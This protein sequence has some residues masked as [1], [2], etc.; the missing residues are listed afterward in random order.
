MEVG[1]NKN[2]MTS[3]NVFK[4]YFTKRIVF[5]VLLILILIAGYKGSKFIQT[6]GYTGLWDFTSTVTSNYF[7]GMDA[8]PEQ[9]SIQIKEKDLKI[10]EI[11]RDKAL[12]RGVIINDL[13][14]EY[15]SATLDYNGKKMK[16]KMRLKGHMTDHIETEN[17][18]SFRIKV[19]DNDTFMGMK[20]FSIQQPGTR[21]YIYEWIYH[22]LMK[23]EDIIA[24][25]YKFINVSI[26]GK[27]WGI[28][29]VE[30]NFD[31]ELIE[32][33]NRKKGPILRLNPDFYWINR[34]NGMKREYITAEFASYYSANFEAYREDK[35]LDDSVQKQYYL[36]AIAL[37]D[38]F[39][40]KKLSVPQVFDVERLAK[41]HAIIDLV[42]G[43]HSIDWS[44]IK[45]YYNPVTAKLEPV[46]YESFSDFSV[47]E[48]SGNYKYVSVDNNEYYEDWHTALFS[49]PD[50]FRAYVKNL[51]RITQKQY[52]DDFFAA[53]NTELD[54]NLK[55]LY[56]EFPYKKFEKKSYYRNQ[57]MIKKILNEA[58][59]AFHAYYTSVTDNTIHLQIG[60][61]ESLPVELKSISVVNSVALPT[62]MFILP[63]KQANEY[64]NYSDYTFVLPSTIKWTDLLISTLKVNYSILGSSIQKES[65][66]F[67]FP[68]TANE[69]I[70]EDLKNKQTTVKMFP[71][72]IVDEENEK[73][74]VKPG[75][76]IITSDLIIPKGYLLIANAGVSI[77]LKNGS[78]IISYSPMIFNGSEDKQIEI[79]S[80]DST[81]Q[82]IALIS[83]SN[84]VFNYVTFKQFA[85]IHDTQWKRRGA[86]TF[87]ESSVA[88][89]H[90]G[91]M[92][93]K[94]EDA[95]NLI[96]SDFEFKNCLF[97]NMHHDAIG[98]DFSNG[99][100]GVCAFEKCNE[101]ALDITMGKVA[102]D[103]ISVFGSNNK[104]ISVK[105]GGQLTGKNVQIENS[106][107][108][109]TA[110]DLSSI[111]LQDVVIKDSK[112]GLVAYKNK[113]GQG[114]PSIKINKLTLTNVKTNYLKE[115]KSSI[116]IDGKEIKE[117][118]NDVKKVLKSD[119]DK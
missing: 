62:K 112:I 72:L 117:E 70:A 110:E 46:A 73:I 52:L 68:H 114:H 25:R 27:D 38:G 85:K 92:S 118:S 56:K 96:R 108:S 7:K 99:T 107:V 47:T 86:I 15:V 66:V 20:R 8:N 82:G 119:K 29:A 13:D 48:I 59:A 44:D 17:K 11:N 40:S 3:R 69:F 55:I 61:I 18:W 74:Y 54:N 9:I 93:I 2:K 23:R 76:Q 14:G 103:D 109:L 98:I 97:K 105:G 88:F 83:A 5:S 19:K 60:S 50:F 51:E 6:K 64:V 115:E 91:F 81:S 41:F 4:K 33:N 32:N 45:Y 36:K 90:C 43:L 34:Y 53:D 101:N 65:S 106:N 94:S 67:P 30:E 10:L 49:D 100:I 21:G 35:V 79:G 75:K 58:P 31:N 111:N 28:Y 16:I 71:F 77:D 37:A 95:I 87:Y 63:S 12:E 1:E 22:E 26:N 80:S 104:A 78:K 39:R 116:I 24:L 113:S 84:S 57:E 42:G 102:V 89:N